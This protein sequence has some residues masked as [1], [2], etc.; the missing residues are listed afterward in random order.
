[1]TIRQFAALCD[2]NPQTLRYYDHVDL[3]KPVQV[4]PWSG[5]RYYD[6]DQALTFVK[7]KNLQAAGFSIEEIRE[8]LDK[9]NLTIAR[10]FD[11]KIAEQ[12]AKLQKMKE[13][14]QSYQS[15]MNIIQKKIQKAKAVIAQAMKDY[16]AMTEFGIGEEQYEELADMV[17]ACFDNLCPD[18]AQTGE[19]FPPDSFT[20]PDLVPKKASFDFLS[21]P[22][23]EVVCSKHGWKYVREF[24]DEI[25]T[26]ENGGDYALYFHVTEEKEK[27][28]IA[29]SST[30]INLLL[31]RNP[32]K[33]LTLSCDFK[34]TADNLNHFWL[35]RRKAG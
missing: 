12:E 32:G 24:L 29:F 13:I 30:V 17:S 16:D 20:S 25:S 35:L 28:G 3:L 11:E 7:I 14:Q 26:L 19:V 34:K 1:M 4:D 31:I 33:K 2:C 22:A 6:E 8:L 15:D 10:A 18:P 23:Y 27:Y 5:Y 9:D 21:D